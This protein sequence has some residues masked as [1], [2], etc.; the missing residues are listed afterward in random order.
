MADSDKNDKVA[1]RLLV[2]DDI[3]MNRD[4][5]QRRLER[6]GVDVVTAASGLEALE[7]I[8]K[9]GVDLLLL[10]INMPDMDGMTVLRVIR[11]THTDSELPVIM[12]TARTD[13]RDVVNALRDGANDYVTKPIDF[14]VLYARIR[15]HL[16][17][18]LAMV[19]LRE[20]EERYALAM[21]GSSAGLWDWDLEKDEL[22]YS[23]RWKTML[24][25]RKDQLG[26]GASEWLTRIH[27]L[28]RTQFDD[29]LSQ[30]L[31]GKSLQFEC[32]YRLRHCD[33]TYLWMMARGIAVR[34]SEGRPVRI[35][36]SQID[37]TEGKTLDLLTGLPNRMFLLAQLQRALERAR[38]PGGLPL[39]VMFLDL[40]R[41][42]L[43]NDSLG[44][45]V[46]DLFIAEVGKRLYSVVAAAEFSEGRTVPLLARLGG[47][48]FALLVSDIEDENLV[49][50]LAKSMLSALDKPFIVN[51][52]SVVVSG[53]IGVVMLSDAHEQPEDLLRDADNAMYRAKA[54]GGGSF[55]YFDQSMH[56]MAVERLEIEADLRQALANDDLDVYFQPI[57]FVDSGEIE[58]FEALVRWIH[59]D[60]GFVPPDAFIGIAEEAGLIWALGKFVLERSVAQM[61][62]W[63]DEIPAAHSMSISVNVARRQLARRGLLEVVSET[64]VKHGLPPQALKLEVTESTVMGDATQVRKTV[65]EL[66]ELGVAISMDDFGTGYSS[67]SLL[68]QLPFDVLKI[69]RSFISRLP[70]EVQLV[71]TILQLAGGFGMSVV[72]E[73]VETKEQLL[74][75]RKLKCKYAQGYFFSR[76]L[77]ASKATE[78][79]LQQITS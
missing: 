34:N 22:F 46:G 12:V 48:E 74:L 59:S 24:G 77:P 78:Y 62:R 10:D 51:D 55:V 6:R 26:D 25:F 43:L 18:K 3:E 9:G 79:I 30:H 56:E 31:S 60:R 40:D 13:S 65:H 20:S 5:L 29:C 14:P 7:V 11:E 73:G 16:S 4:L 50:G 8:R 2:V 72:A 63:R 1:G 35:T 37:D 32:E 33:G 21:R 64:L 75:M 49:D 17:R 45:S 76:P 67:L 58:G 61:A 27:P 70:Q 57:V 23:T 66:R 44:H 47:D 69:D 19:S 15:T 39:T 28:D 54:K 38:G 36:G 71:K 53:S 52:H 41:F 42:K 68:H